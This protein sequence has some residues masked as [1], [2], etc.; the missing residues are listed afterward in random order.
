MIG[1]D[2]IREADN[3]ANV[4]MDKIATWAENNKT[5]FHEEKSKVILT[6]RR[7]RKE[8]KAVALYLNN[9]AIPQIQKLKYLGIIFDYKLSFREHINYEADKCTKL[10]FQLVKSAKI[11][12]GLNHKALQ[13]IY[14][15]GIQPLIV[16]GAPVWSEAMR[17]ENCKARLLRVQSLINIQMAKAYR[18]VSNEA[19]CV[20]TGMMP[21]DMKIEEAA[22]LYQLTKGTANDKTQFDKD[23]EVRYWQHPAEASIC[24]TDEKEE[25]GSMHLYTDGSKTEKGIGSGIAFQGDITKAYSAG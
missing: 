19:L 11:N 22:Q 21:I 8:Q 18:T 13:T 24:S 10:I 14:L 2:S 17:K 15:G 25:N 16:Y 1:A 23:M 12:W 3:V 4:E 5:R 7:K 20:L 9:K 6:T